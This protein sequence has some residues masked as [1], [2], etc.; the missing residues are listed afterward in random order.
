MPFSWR[1]IW[2]IYLKVTELFLNFTQAYEILS[3]LKWDSHLVDYMLGFFLYL[4]NENSSFR[5]LF[6]YIFFVKF[7]YF[8]SC[9][10]FLRLLSASLTSDIIIESCKDR[11][12]PN[13]LQW[14]CRSPPAPQK[15]LISCQTY[16]WRLLWGKS[17]NHMIKLARFC[18]LNWNF[19]AFVAFFPFVNIRNVGCII[20]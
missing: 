20:S 6:L 17:A 2:F 10:L 13:P 1:L 15:V 4:R 7:L 16:V 8:R 5:R 19:I 14:W 9:D 3:F 12:L 18:R 11:R